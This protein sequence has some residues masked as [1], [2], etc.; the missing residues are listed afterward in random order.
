MKAMI[1][2]A[3][4]GTRLKPLTDTLPKALVPVGG[5]PL[6]ELVCRKL[7][8]SSVDEAVVNVHHFAEKIEQWVEHQ[9]IISIQ[10]SDEK[11][12]LLET[13]GAVLHARKQLEGCGS[14]LIHNVD[15][16]SNLDINWFESQVKPDA[17]AT[18]LVSNRKSSRQLLFDPETMELVGWHNLTTGQ[19][20]SPFD[21]ID[22]EKCLSLAFSGIH[23][24][25]DSIFDILQKYAQTHGLCITSEPARFPIIDFYLWACAHYNIYGVC[26]DDLKLV[27]VG[28]LDTLEKAEDFLESQMCIR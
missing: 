4:L 27:D 17:V 14:F 25:S 10:I 5:K 11:S 21:D 15:I 28:K 3:G 19:V 8:A 16:L 13:G 24:M 9:D 22:P 7:K 26:A 6:I 23:I 18:L 1:F 20:R 2:A 12:R